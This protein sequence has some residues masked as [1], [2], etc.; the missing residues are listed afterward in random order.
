MDFK[1]KEY[2]SASGRLVTTLLQDILGMWWRTNRVTGSC[3]LE[4]SPEDLTSGDHLIE[5]SAQSK[6]H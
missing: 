5:H 2:L 4:R 6:S 1:K 3:R